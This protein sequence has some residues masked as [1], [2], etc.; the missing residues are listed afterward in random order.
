M[1]QLNKGGKYV[2]GWSKIGD[3]GM[4]HFPAMALSEYALLSVPEIIIFTGSKITGG[5]CVT[6]RKMLLLSKLKHILTDIP[7]LTNHYIV[8]PGDFIPYK[9][10]SYAWLP[11]SEQGTIVLSQETL[12]FLNLKPGD[13]LMSIRSSDIAF[14]MGAKGPLIERGLNYPG[15]IETF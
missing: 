2:F 10:R 3:E 13:R 9:G 4:L 15:I 11:L 8:K 6:N 5:F 7:E 12:I 14:T 1:P